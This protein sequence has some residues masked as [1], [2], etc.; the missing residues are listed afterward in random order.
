MMAEQ[1]LSADSITNNKLFII[2]SS[3]IN[4]TF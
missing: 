4:I 3:E 1:I 2:D